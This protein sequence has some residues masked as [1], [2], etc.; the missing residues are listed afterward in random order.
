MD[1][2]APISARLLTDSGQWRPERWHAEA[3]PASKIICESHN[4]GVLLDKRHVLTMRIA[5]GSAAGF[6]VK[7]ERK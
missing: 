1:K 4:A 5:P 3:A 2:R 7:H 6:R